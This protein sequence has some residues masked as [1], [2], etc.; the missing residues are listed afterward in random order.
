MDVR[1]LIY[2]QIETYLLFNL[3][4]EKPPFDTVNIKGL[5]N[6]YRVIAELL[7]KIMLLLYCAAI[8]CYSTDNT[9]TFIVRKRYSTTI[10][11]LQHSI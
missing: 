9:I 7:K 4:V 10:V 2:P 11:L 8:A 5:N 6:V 3:K 1:R